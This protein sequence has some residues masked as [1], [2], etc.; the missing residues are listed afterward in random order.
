MNAL[1]IKSKLFTYLK[2]VLQNSL[3]FKTF[4][5]NLLIL[6]RGRGKKGGRERTRDLPFYLFMHP[7]VDSCMCLDQGSNPQRL[8]YQNDTLT[9]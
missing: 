2:K 3:A 6:E 1:T 5:F 7:L 4:F 9:N 8:R